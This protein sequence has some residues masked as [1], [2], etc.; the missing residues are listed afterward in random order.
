MTTLT[1][2]PKLYKTPTDVLPILA[3]FKKDLTVGDLLTGTPTVA[4]SPSGPTLS[5]ASVNTARKPVE[6]PDGSIDH[7]ANAGQA[8]E[9]TM[10]GGTASTTYTVTVTCATTG[11]RTFG[12]RPIIVE[13]ST[14]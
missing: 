11:G 5:A 2:Q 12:A 7:Y 13:V 9:F 10:S 8:V 1:A 3:S 4:V 14:T 6:L